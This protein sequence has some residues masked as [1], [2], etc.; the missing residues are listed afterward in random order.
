MKTQEYTVTWTINISANCA[1][2]A[3]ASAWEILKEPHNHSATN[4]DVAKGTHLHEGGPSSESFDMALLSEPQ[5][6][7]LE[8]LVLREQAELTVAYAE[9]SLKNAHNSVSQLE[10]DLAE[11]ENHND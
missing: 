11:L 8:L 6:R 7:V 5:K 9:S 4:L 2:A 3:A 10:R 1:V